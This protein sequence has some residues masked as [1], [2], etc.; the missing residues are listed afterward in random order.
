MGRRRLLPK[1]LTDY[2]K[3]ILGVKNDEAVRNKIIR[4]VGTQYPLELAAALFLVKIEDN[5]HD[6]KFGI[7]KE[8]LSQLTLLGPITTTQPSQQQSTTKLKATRKK[9]P[10]SK[11]FGEIPPLTPTE[12]DKADNMADVY[13][14]FYVIENSLRKLIIKVLKN[15][16]GDNWWDDPN[17]IPPNIQ[18]AA[19]KNIAD[20]QAKGIPWHGRR[21]KNVHPIY[22]IYFAQLGEVIRKNWENF[23]DILDE[24]L[25]KVMMRDLNLSRNILMHCNPLTKSDVDNLNYYF[26]NLK[27]TLGKNRSKIP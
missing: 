18:N 11:R 4:E 23:K 15:H 19:S 1:P 10:S 22:Y 26:N 25:L 14:K 3:P 8:T 24:D 27:R 5:P 6:P 21:G 13:Y 20:E 16:H 7:S 17:V 12:T 2:L 9:T